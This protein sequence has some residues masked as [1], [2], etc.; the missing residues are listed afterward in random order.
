MIS[1]TRA[2]KLRT[3]LLSRE[4]VDTIYAYLDHAIELFTAQNETAKRCAECGP[5]AAFY[6]RQVDYCRHVIAG[7]CDLRVQLEKIDAKRIG[8]VP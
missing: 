5:D 1:Y 2:G 6:W 3:G 7:L 8:P 4:E